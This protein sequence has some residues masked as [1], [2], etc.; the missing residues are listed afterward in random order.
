MPIT[1]RADYAIRLMY[2]LAQLPA[3]ATLSLRDLCEAADVPVTFG[4]PL[5][6]FLAHAGLIR[7]T[8]YRDQLLMLASP[9]G[10]IKMADIVRIADPQF[11]LSQCTH[12]ADCCARTPECGVNRMWRSLELMLWQRLEITSLAHVVAGGG[13][14]ASQPLE[15]AMAGTMLLEVARGEKDEQ[16]V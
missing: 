16:A 14:M 6:E 13:T 4:S 1:R 15:E 11:S 2:E 8:G 9:P 10:E 3:D 7:T 5:V 12:D